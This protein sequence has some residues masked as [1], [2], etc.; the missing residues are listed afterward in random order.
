MRPLILLTFLLGLSCSSA[1]KSKETDAQTNRPYFDFDQV[2]YF[3]SQI[4]ESEINKFVTNN[5][6]SSNQRLLSD[7]LLNDSPKYL[8]SL[9]T[10][11]LERRCGYNKR[12][13]GTTSVIS[14]NK[15]FSERDSAELRSTKCMPV[16]RDILVLLKSNKITGLAKICFECEQYYFVGQLI[17]TKY[18]GNKDDYLRLKRALE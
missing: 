16:Y 15:I 13:L 1:N 12:R 10:N 7:V 3:E 14:I 9:D 4:Q 8:S 5:D 6:S 2:L 18:F 11:I 17:E